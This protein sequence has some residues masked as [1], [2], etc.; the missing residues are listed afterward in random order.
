MCLVETQI[1]GLFRIHHA[2]PPSLYIWPPVRLA[3]LLAVAL[4]STLIVDKNTLAV[5][6]YWDYREPSSVCDDRVKHE[7]METPRQG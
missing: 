7:P 2:W 5:S 3:S 1:Q 4:P 6:G